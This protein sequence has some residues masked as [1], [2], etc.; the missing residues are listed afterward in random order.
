MNVKYAKKVHIHLNIQN[1][2]KL[3]FKSVFNVILMVLKAVLQISLKWIMDFGEK[4]LKICN[5]LTVINPLIIISVKL[6]VNIII[7]L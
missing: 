2:T 3:M 7:K 4:T 6:K 5:I 1:L